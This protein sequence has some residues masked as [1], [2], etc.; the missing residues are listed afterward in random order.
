MI[1]DATRAIIRRMLLKHEGEVLHPY[2][3]TRGKITIGVGRNLTDRG[4]TTSESRTM[5]EHD[6]EVAIADVARAVP[7]S[8]QLST[9]AQLVLVDIDFNAGVLGLL[10]FRRL[11]AALQ[12]GDRAT[13][14]AEVLDSALAPRRA[15]DLAAMLKDD[16]VTV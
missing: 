13:A 8:T 1:D 7:W 15:R 10:G 12:R 9:P 14:A 2:V 6:I 5:L 11:L 4:I 16:T 3:D